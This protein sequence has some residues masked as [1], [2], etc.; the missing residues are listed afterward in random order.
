MDLIFGESYHTVSDLVQSS[1][2]PPPFGAV[3]RLSSDCLVLWMIWVIYIWLNLNCIVE[4]DNLHQANYLDNR[5]IM[6]CQ[7]PK[8][9][10]KSTVKMVIDE[11]RVKAQTKPKPN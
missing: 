10:L 1:A 9:K 3:E 5:Q 7:Q 6:L 8:E 4:T 11:T 2:P